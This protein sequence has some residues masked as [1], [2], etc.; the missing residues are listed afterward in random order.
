MLGRELLLVSEIAGDVM[1]RVLTDYM[2]GIFP[3]NDLATNSKSDFPDLFIKS[4]DGIS[5][6]HSAQEKE[7][8]RD[9][10]YGMR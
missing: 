1:S 3:S 8:N 4:K 10:E 7:E 5:N 9:K 6:L 2:I